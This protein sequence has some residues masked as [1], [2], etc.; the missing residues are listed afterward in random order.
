[1]SEPFQ[2]PFLKR[3]FVFGVFVVILDHIYH[4]RQRAGQ[5]KDYAD[6]SFS[7][8]ILSH[9]SNTRFALG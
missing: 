6:V 4:S 1:V 2:I 5:V 9:S 3:S 7:L 8:R